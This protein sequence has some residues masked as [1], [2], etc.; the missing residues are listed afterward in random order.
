MQFNLTSRL[1]KPARLVA[2]GCWRGGAN[3][4]Q[5]KIRIASY[6]SH[7]VLLFL[8]MN[9]TP[10]SPPNHWLLDMQT[11]WT[12]MM[13]ANCHF[14]WSDY[15]LVI[16]VLVFTKVCNQC[17]SPVAAILLCTS[18]ICHVFWCLLFF[19]FFGIFML[20]FAHRLWT[21]S[22]LFSNLLVLGVL[23]CREPGRRC[24]ERLPRPCSRAAAAGYLRLARV[25]WPC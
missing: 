23:V 10:C 25:G 7:E 3:I 1:P 15:L 18:N 4:N 6:H 22:V 11:I 19:L 20:H 13:L 24:C 2:G 14:I 12:K 21:N 8:V 16:C 17:Y 9:W 5:D